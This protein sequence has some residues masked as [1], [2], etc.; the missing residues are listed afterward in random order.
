MKTLKILFAAFIFVGFATAAMADDP[1]T[2][3][4]TGE[5]DATATV[6]QAMNVIGEQDLTFGDVSPGVNKTVD[7]DDA[8]NGGIFI[9]QAG[10][11]AS[12]QYNITT[13]DNLSSDEDGS[14]AELSIDGYDGNW[15]EDNV[16][17]NATNELSFGSDE[18]IT[19]PGT[20]EIYVFFGA[21]VN[22]T[23]DQEAGSYSGEITLTAEY[24]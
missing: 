22:P 1:T 4:D 20:S 10:S 8:D 24:N 13:I 5:I 19:V 15:G 12:I 17:E 14:T 2:Q 23:N 11:G 21:T 7:W 16:T 9:I 3:D 6:L 18:T